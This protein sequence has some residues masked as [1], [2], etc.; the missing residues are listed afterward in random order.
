MF[1]FYAVPAWQL[2]KPEDRMEPLAEHA[3]LLNEAFARTEYR[4]E[5]PLKRAEQ[6][7]KDN[8]FS[9]YARSP[10]DLPA[11]LRLA[12]QLLAHAAMEAGTR[13]RVW[14]CTCGTRYAVPEAL[15]RPVSIRCE[16]CMQTLDLELAKSSGEDV[17]AEPRQ[18]RIN[19]CRRAYADFFREAMA[20]GW[21]VL[22]SKLKA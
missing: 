10:N 9:I 18:G 6:L 22:V 17:L 7:L 16:R 2:V 14:T 13:A 4:G 8:P 21:P 5:N 11:L 12:D 20:R 19:E 3:E 15:L 1:R